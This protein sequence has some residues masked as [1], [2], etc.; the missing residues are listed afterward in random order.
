MALPQRCSYVYNGI[1]C[2]F[3][4]LYIVSIEGDGDDEYMITVVCEDHRAQMEVRLKALQ[5]RNT[6][7]QGKTKFQEIRMVGTDCVRGTAD[8]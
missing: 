1:H 8:G 4:P 6:I 7:P 2:Q 3:S 5:H